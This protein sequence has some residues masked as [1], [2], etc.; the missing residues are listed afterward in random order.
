MNILKKSKEIWNKHKVEILLFGGSFIVGSITSV[1]LYKTG[2]ISGARK[3]FTA[4]NDVFNDMIEG[5]LS[6]NPEIKEKFTDG[7]VDALGEKIKQGTIRVQKDGTLKC[8]FK[9]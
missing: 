2:Q 6:K 5:T 4:C 7:F 1:A 3:G 9:V 8:I